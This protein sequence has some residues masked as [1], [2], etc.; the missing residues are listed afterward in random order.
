MGGRRESGR[1]SAQAGVRAARLHRRPPGNLEKYA[2]LYLLP[3]SSFQKC[4]GWLGNGLV[5][6]SSPLSPRTAF[7]GWEE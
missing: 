1:G 2:F 6:T 4:V 7:P 3:S 5:H